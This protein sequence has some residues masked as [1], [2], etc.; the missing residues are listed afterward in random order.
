MRIPFSRFS[1]HPAFA[2]AAVNICLVLWPLQ[3]LSQRLPATVVP[4]HYTLA[5]APDLKAATFSGDESIDVNISQ[6]TQLITLNAIE[7]KFE[8]ADIQY[9][10]GGIQTGSVSLDTERQ[11]ATL[12]FPRTIPAGDATLHIRFTGILNN[13]LRG[14]Y[15]SKTARRSYAVTQFEATDAR[16]AFPCF[17]E[18][19]FKATYDISL[20]IDAD[21]TAI[22]NTAIVSDTPGPGANKHTVVFG[23]TPRMSTYLVALLV[24]DFQCTGARQDG[25]DIRVCATPDKVEL[26]PFALGVAKFALH[27]YDDYFGIHYPLKKL[28]FIGVPDF[29]AG[30]ME[31]FGAITFRETDLLVDPKTASI[32]VQRNAAV[33]ITHEMAHQW[34]GDLVTMQWWDNIWL[35]EGFATWME[36]KP[37]AAMHPEWNMPEEVEIDEQNTLDTD[38]QPTTRA[39]RAKADTPDEIDEMFDDIAYGKASDVLLMVE[40]YVGTETF[41]KGVQAYLK[42]HE[43]ANAT[44]EDFWNAQAEVSGEPVDKIMESLIVQPGEPILSFDEPQNGNVR[45]AQERFFLNA[46]TKIDPDQAWTLPVCFKADAGAHACDLLLMAAAK[47]TDSASPPFFANA[48][49]T[50]YYRTSYANSDRLALAAH[51]E[52]DLTPVERIS[53]L[54]DTW[55]LAHANRLDVSNYLD[56]AAALKADS[57]AEVVSSAA[58]KIATIAD[59]I[60]STKDERN[61][62]AAWIRRN[63]GPEYAKLGAPSTGDSPNTLELRTHLLDLLVTQGNDADLK[64]QAHRI[65]EKFLD[66]PSAVDPTL[67]HAALEA[68]AANGDAALFDRLQ[69]VYETSADPA[70]QEGALRLL[71]QFHEPALLERGLE[72]SVS[73]KVRNQDTALQ[74]RRGLQSPQNRD[75]VWQFIKSHWDA[76]EADLT[77]DLG[78][79]LVSATGNFCTDAARNDVKTF[80]AT[81]PVPASDMALKHALES[82]DGCVELRRLQEPNLNAWLAAQGGL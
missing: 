69:K 43:Y 23:T 58:G 18:P 29:E 74:L 62:L 13:E 63:Y 21:D 22:S 12:A 79:Y 7:I 15:L 52:S 37:V 75:Q 24:G 6:P 31:N 72:Y 46:G 47:F 9:R 67:S 30:A 14:F 5:F 54:G 71:V 80:F 4:T 76:V 16:R 39:I 25:V 36:A 48:G 33:D 81:H 38:A 57:N 27:Y 17:D 64:A 26:T 50:G 41:R 42:A 11:Q 3:S 32:A 40:N 77:T 73:D 51:A 28:D 59:Q 34:F 8:S 60:A 20:I 35:N 56:L 55:A 10:D 1:A 66:D 53:L 78:A 82:I 19:A 61:E 68:A 2:A 70:L 49:G 65:A 44:A 45:I